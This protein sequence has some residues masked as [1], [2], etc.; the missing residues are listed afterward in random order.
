MSKS[1]VITVPHALG[2]DEARRRVAAEITQLKT[3]Y[4]DKFAHSEVNWAGDVADIRV[5][6]LAQE[7]TAHIDVNTDTVRVE[8]FL[9]WILA[10]LA[11]KVEGKLTT[12]ARDT[13][14]ITHSSKKN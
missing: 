6:A 9:P 4:V 7:V 5:V 11:S 1:I 10:S 2:K 8:V 3:A 14:A 12:T 13:L